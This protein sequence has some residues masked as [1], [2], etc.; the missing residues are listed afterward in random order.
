MIFNII[1]IFPA[2]S[3]LVTADFFQVTPAD[4]RRLFQM[5]ENVVTDLALSVPRVAERSNVAGKIKELYPMSRVVVKDDL[6]NTY[7]MIFGWRS[8]IFLIISLV[9]LIALLI[10][11]IDQLSGL[12]SGER[13]EIALLRCLGWT[14]ALIIRARLYEVGLI[15]LF[16]WLT[17]TVLAWCHIFLLGGGLVA[18]ALRGWS[19]IFPQAGFSPVLDW[20]SVG[21][22]FCIT[23]IP[24]LSVALIPIWKIAGIDP[25]AVK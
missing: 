4:F 7:K 11:T 14:P 13:K 9:G 25:E 1:D 6:R 12:W 19:S 18:A 23:V 17:G 10:F 21:Y 16:S 8:S 24:L 3:E 2:E 22:L 20:Q 5:P 15:A